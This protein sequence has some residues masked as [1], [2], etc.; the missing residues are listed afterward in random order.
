MI[1]KNKKIVTFF[2]CISF[3]LF[4]CDDDS[5]LCVDKFQKDVEAICPTVYDPVCGCNGLTYSNDCEAKKSGLKM[6]IPGACMGPRK[7]PK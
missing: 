5:T 3:F 2:Y 7:T 6:W 4:S 1:F